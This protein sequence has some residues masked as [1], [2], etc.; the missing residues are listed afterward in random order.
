MATATEE[1]THPLLVLEH[2]LA[3]LVSEAHSI[4]E[5]TD[6]RGTDLYEMP[7]A[8]TNLPQML[9]RAKAL[10]DT[11]TRFVYDEIPSEVSAETKFRRFMADEFFP[12]VRALTSVGL[13]AQNADRDHLARLFLLIWQRAREAESLCDAWTA[14]LSGETN[15]GE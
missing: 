9:A 10:V 4:I 15:A 11:L 1:V 8:D 3:G 14:E 2:K 5:R 13:D 12:D 7:G 6:G